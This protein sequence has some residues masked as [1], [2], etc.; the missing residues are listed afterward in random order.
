MIERQNG[1][2]LFRLIASFF[3]LLLHTTYGILPSVY[4]DNLRI[5]ARWAVPFFFILS[6]YLLNR[7]ISPK[8]QIS[9]SNIEGTISQLISTFITASLIYIPLNH[10]LHLSFNNVSFLIVGTFWHL[11]FL[12]SMILG[13]FF[14]WNIYFAGYSILLFPISISILIISL[15]SD[16]YKFLNLFT[17]DSDLSRFLLS[18]PLMSLGIYIGSIENKLK[19]I[20]NIT[21][22]VASLSLFGIISQ[23]FEA[24]FLYVH[25]HV[26]KF[27]I[28]FLITTF[29][30]S[31]P[32]FLLSILINLRDNIISIWGRK[33]S[34][35]IYLYHIYTYYFINRIIHKFLSNNYEKILPFSPILCFTLTLFFA[36]LLDKFS[37]PIFKVLNGK[38]G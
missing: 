18:I 23:F 13:Y 33:Y 6:G 15:I 3:I 37:K 12:G 24:H 28:Q 20:K 10:L 19:K 31:V 1:I 2:D 30:T 17:V 11:W 22:I 26:N 27:S 4:S 36:I 5:S 29:L 9:L 7:K 14:I 35:F 34:L 38:F 25:F 16:S 8:N 21:F 32:I